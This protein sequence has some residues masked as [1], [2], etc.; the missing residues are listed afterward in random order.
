[1]AGVRGKSGPPG[2][3]NNCRR[4]WQAFWRRR[5]LRA[6]DKWIVPTLET[7]ASGLES[8]KPNATE[9]ELRIIE[10]AQTARG[11]TMLILAEAARSGFIE[12][13]DGSWDLAPGAQAL[14]KFLSIERQALQTL[15]LNRRA[16]PA[17]SLQDLL[18]AAAEK[19][20]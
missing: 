9:G 14:A 11:A 3:L 8:D 2:N 18:T 16:K 4:P 5:A 19:A 7:Y 15:G 17:G 6:E 1:M 20:K 10:I 12:K 13:R